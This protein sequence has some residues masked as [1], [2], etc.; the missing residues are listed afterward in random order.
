M[1]DQK[2]T[3]AAH[4]LVQGY[5]DKIISLVSA[6]N[7]GIES[8]ANTRWLEQDAEQ[9]NMSTQAVEM[10]SVSTT[11]ADLMS[12][13][14]APISSILDNAHVSGLVFKHSWDNMA[15]TNAQ[16]WCEVPA[17]AVVQWL[18]NANA[19]WVVKTV[20]TQEEPFTGETKIVVQINQAAQALIRIKAIEDNTSLWHMRC[21]D[22]ELRTEV[23]ALLS[24]M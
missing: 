7:A 15:D 24:D 14:F 9:E 4:G 16:G 1:T 5:Q 11:R 20:I 17:D 6:G 10:L 23:K 19:C 3:E 2:M 8:I 18:A 22:T 13:P 12:E 21:Q